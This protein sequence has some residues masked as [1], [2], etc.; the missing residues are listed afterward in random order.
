M[1]IRIV[2]TT[3]G[4]NTGPTLDVYAF[5]GATWS[6]V[7]TTIPKSLFLSPGYIVSI[8]NDTVMVR[9]TN[10]LGVCTNYFDLYITTTTT[11]TV[12]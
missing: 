7:V 5:N 8:P 6:V 2:L 9:I 11:T 4:S 10:H 12:I 3:L 1:T